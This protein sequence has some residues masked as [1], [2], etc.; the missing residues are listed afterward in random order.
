MSTEKSGFKEAFD[1]IFEQVREDIK[2]NLVAAEAGIVLPE[3]TAVKEQLKISGTADVYESLDENGNYHFEASQYLRGG[4]VILTITI[5]SPDN[6]YTAKLWSS[7]GGGRQWDNMYINQKESA[8][9]N[10]NF[11]SKTTVKLEVHA[12]RARN[13]GFYARIGY[14]KLISL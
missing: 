3:S 1:L 2:S 8:I 9:I 5:L 4:T 7:G 14:T 10:M 12:S 6:T 11:W 13:V